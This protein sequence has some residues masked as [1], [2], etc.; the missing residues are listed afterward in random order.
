PTTPEPSDTVIVAI[1]DLFAE[2]YLPTRTP[3]GEEI[4]Y[5]PEYEFLTMAEI[6]TTKLKPG[7]AEKW[8]SAADGSSW[9]FYLR[10]G[11]PWHDDWGEFTAEDVKYSIERIMEED[12]VNAFQGRFQKYIDSVEIVDTYTVII[13][14]TEPRVLFPYDLWDIDPYVPIFSKNYV[15]TVGDDEASRHPIGTGPYKFLEHRTGEYVKHEALD[16]HWRIV[17]D[18]KYLIVKTVPELSTRVAMLRRG[19]IDVTD[20]STE[21]KSEL[22]GYG[23]KVLRNKDAQLTKLSFFGQYIPELRK[24]YDPTVPWVD[25]DDPERA[26]KVRKAMAMA[27]DRQGIVDHMFQGMGRVLDYPLDFKPGDPWT[28]PSWEPIPYDPEGAKRLLAEAGYPDGFSFV[29][30][31]VPDTGLPELTDIQTAVAMEWEKIGLFVTLGTADWAVWKPKMMDRAIAGTTAVTA[32]GSNFEPL[33]WVEKLQTSYGP[34]CFGY[35]S[36]RLDDLVAEAL[37][38]TDY[39]ERGKVQMKIGEIFHNEYRQI[40]MLALDTIFAVSDKI[41]SWTLSPIAGCF[42]GYENIIKAK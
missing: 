14:L 21:L 18:F 7:L 42:M 25:G 34:Y 16:E 3:C 28:D 13:H 8:E 24:G 29:H 26:L 1:S 32:C 41:E 39:D 10:E 17:P 11:V 30:W 38:K 9:T 35:E 31:L 27:I 36:Y 40:P 6:G 23:F 19:E 15:E 5:V 33:I 20:L 12:S 22:E 2:T 37:T 4:A